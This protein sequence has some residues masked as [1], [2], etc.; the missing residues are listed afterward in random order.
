LRRECDQE[1][2]PSLIHERQSDRKSDA[3]D[4]VDDLSEDEK[5]VESDVA[6]L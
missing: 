3:S 1:V 4:S 6:S 5:A 2:A